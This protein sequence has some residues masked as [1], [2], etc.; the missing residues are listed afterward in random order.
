MSMVESEY[1]MLYLHASGEDIVN[2][3]GLLNHLR[4]SFQINIIAMEYPGYSF[5]AESTNSELVQFNARYLYQF[6]VEKMGFVEQNVVVVGRSIG[7]AFACQLAAEFQPGALVLVSPFCTLQEAATDMIG[8]FLASFVEEKF[9][10][11]VAIRRA[12]CPVLLIHGEKDKT[13]SPTHSKKLIAN[14][15]NAKNAKAVYPPNMEH[16]AFD[17]YQD[18]SEPMR[19]F[20]LDNNF[21]LYRQNMKGPVIP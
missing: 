21:Q 4:N 16:D 14:C 10:N 6:L 5:Y 7:S 2:S 8:S 18:V 19:K 15:I 1:L 12:R 11:I 17:Y 13:I 9:D 20:L 3:Y